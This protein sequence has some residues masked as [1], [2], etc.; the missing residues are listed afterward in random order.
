MAEHSRL[1]NRI[2]TS[3]MRNEGVLP[4]I[5]YLSPA[6]TGASWRLEQRPG[7]LMYLH[8]PSGVDYWTGFRGVVWLRPEVQWQAPG[9]ATDLRVEP[10]EEVTASV[11]MKLDGNWGT[12]PSPRRVRLAL[13]FRTDSGPVTSF[14]TPAN[15]GWSE[16]TYEVTAVAPPDATSAFLMVQA[17]MGGTLPTT[18]S[19]FAYVISDAYFGQAGTRSGVTEVGVATAARQGVLADVYAR[20]KHKIPIELAGIDTPVSGERVELAAWAASSM[21]LSWR[22]RQVSGPPVVLRRHEGTATFIAPDVTRPT[23]VRIAVMASSIVSRNRSDWEFF[24]LEVQPALAHYMANSDVGYQPFTPRVAGYGRGRRE[25]WNDPSVPAGFD[26]GSRYDAEIIDLGIDPDD[27]Q[28]TEGEPPAR[29]AA[30]GIY[31][32]INTGDVYRNFGEGY[33]EDEDTLGAPRRNAYWIN[34]ATGDVS[35]WIEEP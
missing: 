19:P 23:A 3:F 18:P 22:W 26:P 17:E 30:G 20:S 6:P 5:A 31:I 21:V 1:G 4:H 2:D 13:E 8:F 34:P 27:V 28:F 14:S 7:G 29:A 25:I 15:V 10:G 33:N 9:R 12:A 24:D 16:A 32:D 11:T 35:K